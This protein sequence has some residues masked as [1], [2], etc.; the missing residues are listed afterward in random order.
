MYSHLLEKGALPKGLHTLVF[1]GT[2]DMPLTNLPEGLKVL[3]FGRDINGGLKYECFPIGLQELDV[4]ACHNL[5]IDPKLLPKNLKR[6][7][8]GK[9]CTVVRD[10]LF[11]CI[12]IIYRK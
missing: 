5:S 2:Y 7:I 6:L 3:R 9:G 4:A 11:P 1:E 10:T 12:N 8:L